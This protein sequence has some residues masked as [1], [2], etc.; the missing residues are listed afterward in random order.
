MA[1]LSGQLDHVS[2]TN[3]SLVVS[4]LPKHGTHSFDVI[5]SNPG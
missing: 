3:G 1:R 4:E 5:I 2:D